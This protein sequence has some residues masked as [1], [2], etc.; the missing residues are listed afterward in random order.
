MSKR[1]R[2]KKRR[3]Q[4]RQS[5]GPRN[6]FTLGHPRARFSKHF[7]KYQHHQKHLEPFEHDVTTNPFFCKEDPDRI[8]KLRWSGKVSDAGYPRGSYR[9]KQ[10]QLRIVYSINK[11]ERVV[12]PLDADT[13]GEIGYR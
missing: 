8:Q 13:A 12:T 1:E 3:R 9:W 6:R 10:E 5:P 2:R 7:E 11:S 4:R